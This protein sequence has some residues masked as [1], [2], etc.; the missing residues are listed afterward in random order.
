[1]VADGKAFNYSSIPAHIV[2]KSWI[3]S[4]CEA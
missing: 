3:P 2:Q 4:Y 1:M